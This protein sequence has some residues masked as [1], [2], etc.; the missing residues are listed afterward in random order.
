MALENSK[1]LKVLWLSPNLNHYKQK[2]LNHLHRNYE[3][4]LT[5]LAGTGRQNMGDAGI[6]NKNAS[7]IIQTDISKAYFGMSGEI[8]KI[9]RQNFND[10][11]WIMIP[12]EKKNLILIIYVFYLRFKSK[13]NG[14]NVKLFSYNH[15]RLMS[16]GGKITIIDKAL[17]RFFYRA[18]D[19]IIFYT[20]QSRDEVV[21]EGIIS[22]DKAFYANNTIYTKEVDENYTFQYPKQDNYTILFIGR[23][24]KNKKIEILL[25]YFIKLKRK[26]NRKLNLIIIGDGPQNTIINKILKTEPNIRWVGSL[27]NESEISPFMKE[28]N[29]VFNPG[30][31]GLC[32]NH[33]F[34]YGRPYITLES[35]THAP[36]INYVRNGFNGY[37]L[38]GDDEHNINKILEILTCDDMTIY[39]NAYSTGKML[40]IDNWCDQ[41]VDALRLRKL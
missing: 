18:Y 27:T 34:C 37:I 39:E 15:P 5:I 38:S 17:T 13:F 6:L 33:S 9:L 8:R 22:L 11:D 25:A 1:N 24:V 28:A 20:E 35:G 32:I 30:H 29:I 36:E 19:R 7:K 2:F 14:N 3:I 40:S 26:M 21:E 41:I 23:L 10:F 4:D 16:K 31:S 12:R